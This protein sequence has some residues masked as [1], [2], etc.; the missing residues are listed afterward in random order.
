MWAEDE[1]GGETYVPHALSKRARS[2]QIMTETADI[3][4]GRY[5]P[6]SALEAA[7][8][9]VSGGGV[10]MR[11]R[12]NTTQIDKVEVLVPNADPELAAHYI[13]REFGLGIASG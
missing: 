6:A 8:G 3:F 10:I 7:D 4:G 5:I 9:L 2:E 11:G 13:G 1:T 12:G